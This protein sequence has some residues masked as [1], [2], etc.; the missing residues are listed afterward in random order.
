MTRRPWKKASDRKKATEP[1][2]MVMLDFS[3]KTRVPSRKGEWCYGLAVDEASERIVV[4]PAKSES[5]GTEL[6][7][8]VCLEG[9]VPQMIRMDN[10][11]TFMSKEFVTFCDQRN[12]RRTYTVSYNSN[13]NAQAEVHVGIVNKMA[14]V[15][16]RQ[17]KI[18]A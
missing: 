3:G 15:L 6:L 5:K 4:L 13:Q 9:G 12:I 14:V 16:L 17:R 11:K 7:K 2:E 8:K 18:T 10:A 1:N